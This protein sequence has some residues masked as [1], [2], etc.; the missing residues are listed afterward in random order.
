MGD[1]HAPPH[2]SRRRRPPGRPGPIRRDRSATAPKARPP[3]QFRSESLQR[4]KSQPRP[5]APGQARLRRVR[6]IARGHSESNR[7]LRAAT[8]ASDLGLAAP[9][10][11][12]V[13][14]VRKVTGSTMR[15]VQMFGRGCRATRAQCSRDSDT[16]VCSHERSPIDNLEA[17]DTGVG[18]W[19]GQFHDRSFHAR[20][21][22]MF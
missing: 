4:S 10:T 11:C 22:I 17:N 21:C 15:Q 14:R 12:P 19:G 3:A 8:A 2:H 16:P 9:E 6:V 1:R 5:A 20:Q 18:G 7:D 13:Q